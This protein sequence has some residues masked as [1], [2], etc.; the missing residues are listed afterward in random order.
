MCKVLDEI[1]I[2]L[3]TSIVSASSHTNCVSLSQQKCKI[4]LTLINLYPNEYIQELRGYS[5]SFNLSRCCGSCNT[6]NKLSYEVCAPNK[7]EDLN[8]SMFIV[9]TGINECKTLTKYIS[10]MY[11]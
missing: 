4:Q 2:G 9:I 10:Q 11:M 1:F 6:L 8:L 7:T 5:F 3:L